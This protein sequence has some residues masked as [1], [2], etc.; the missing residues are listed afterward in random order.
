M[1]TDL[2]SLLAELTQD[3]ELVRVR[4][5]INDNNRRAIQRLVGKLKFVWHRCA[6][7]YVR[8]CERVLDIRL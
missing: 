6:H 1:H 8:V 5:V 7:A 2:R 4:Y 3:F